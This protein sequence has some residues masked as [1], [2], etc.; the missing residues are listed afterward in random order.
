MWSRWTAG[1]EAGWKRDC[2]RRRN[3]ESFLKHCCEWRE[4]GSDEKRGVLAWPGRLF[5]ISPRRF[6]EKMAGAEGFEPSPDTLTVRCPTSWTT[7][8]RGIAGNE[9]G[10]AKRSSLRRKAEAKY[11]SKIPRG[12]RWPN[13]AK[14][15]L[16]RFLNQLEW[17]NHQS[18][19]A[20]GGFAAY[21]TNV[22]SEKISCGLS[23]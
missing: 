2:R 14:G 19:G 20:H 23:K 8:Q 3:R 10:R 4:L 5:L 1:G 11:L 21:G 17:M 7:P 9:P 13:R 16:Q 6:F 15:H 12:R 22:N 18:D